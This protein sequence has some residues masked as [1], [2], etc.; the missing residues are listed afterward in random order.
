MVQTPSGTL[1]ERYEHGTRLRK[2][3]ARE[4][5]A[6]LCGPADRDAAAILAADRSHPGA[7]AGAGPLR[8][9]AG[10]PVR[11]P[12]RRRRGDGGG[13]PASTDRRDSGPGLRRLPSDEL[14]GIRH[15]GT[16]HRVRHQRFRR[17]PAWRGFHRGSQAAGGERRGRRFGG[18]ISRKSGRGRSR[19]PLS[20]PIARRMRSLAKFSPLEIWHSRIELA[21]EIERIEIA[22][23]GASCKA[24]SPRRATISRTTTTS[25]IW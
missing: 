25:P 24:F 19:R 16:E 6:D 10:K 20:R 2:K 14:R 17:D 8:A 18:Q 3:A 4:K 22:R 9:H 13:S 11:L 5:H 23:S 21:R 1:A 7:R 15:P 12:A